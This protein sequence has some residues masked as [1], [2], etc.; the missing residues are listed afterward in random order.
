MARSEAPSHIDVHWDHADKGQHYDVTKASTQR[1]HIDVGHVD[2]GHID[3]FHADHG[4]VEVGPEPPTDPHVD[5]APEAKLH[6]DLGHVD[7]GHLDLG[8]LDVFHIDVHVDIT[9]PPEPDDKLAVESF[10][11]RMN[12]LI[13]GTEARVIDFERNREM[14]A[15]HLKA[16]RDQLTKALAKE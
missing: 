7:V 8:H 15:A 4:H 16:L 14:L 6:V 5:V 2:V 3:L 11:A 10:V 13:S 9:R 12:A 1:L